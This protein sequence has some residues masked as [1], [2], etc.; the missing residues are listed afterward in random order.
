MKAA[1]QEEFEGDLQNVCSF[2]KEDLEKAVLN[3]Q[4]KTF[5]V[6][7]QQQQHRHSKNKRKNS[8]V[9]IFDIKSYFESISPSQIIL[10]SQVKRVMQLILVMPATNA[11]SERSFSALI[12]VN[13]Y[14]RS[15]MNQDRLNYLM[16]LHVHK[17]MTD[18]LKIKHILNEFAVGDSVHCYRIIIC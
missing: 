11:S 12:R 18:G 6:H 8:S 13:N 14:L 9:T 3:A 10:L 5:G 17:G 4:L 7:V 2:Y 1:K 16:L 15:T